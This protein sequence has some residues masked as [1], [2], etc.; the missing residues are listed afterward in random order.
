[1][2]FRLYT[3]QYNA[4]L[5]GATTIDVV[6]NGSVAVNGSPLAVV[7]APGPFVRQATVAIGNGTQGTYQAGV[8]LQVSVQLRDAFL[9]SR[10]VVSNF[11][12][13]QQNDYASS[14]E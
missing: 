14:V 6:F 13:Q 4:T 3:V 9:V 8:E 1:M 2:L 7:V 11:A 5:A 12:R 10:C